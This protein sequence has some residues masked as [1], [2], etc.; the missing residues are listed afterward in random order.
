[1]FTTILLLAIDR[2]FGVACQTNI[3]ERLSFIV[4]LTIASTSAWC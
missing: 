2:E 1:M 3:A 4:H